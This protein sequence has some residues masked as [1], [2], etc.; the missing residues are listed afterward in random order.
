MNW[1]YYEAGETRQ[2][3]REGG[4]NGFERPIEPYA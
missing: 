1:L 3:P 2:E 4:F